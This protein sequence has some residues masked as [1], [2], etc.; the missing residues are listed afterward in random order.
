MLDNVGMSLTPNARRPLFRETIPEDPHLEWPKLVAHHVKQHVRPLRNDLFGKKI[1]V[2]FRA[3]FLDD[4]PHQEQ[5]F[6]NP[7]DRSWRCQERPK[8]RELKQPVVLEVFEAT[9]T[10]DECES[11]FRWPGM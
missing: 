4:I 8:A 5:T 9:E 3:I 10:A 2:D 7:E 11:F 6:W 1:P